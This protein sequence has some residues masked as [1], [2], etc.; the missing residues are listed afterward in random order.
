MSGPDDDVDW[1]ALSNGMGTVMPD[2]TVIQPNNEEDMKPKMKTMTISQV[3][4]PEWWSGAPA[5]TPPHRYIVD[6]VRNSTTPPL[7]DFLTKAQAD[8][9]C[10]KPDW[11]VIIK[12]GS[13]R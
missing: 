1:Y 12:N 3:V 4:N 10:E 5:A 6:E 11:T 2:G 13:K 8:E 9:Y 7:R